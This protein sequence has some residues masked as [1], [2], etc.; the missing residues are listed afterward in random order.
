MSSNEKKERIYALICDEAY[1]PMKIK[2]MAI[3]LDLPKERRGELEEVLL[4]LE[5]E[6]KIERTAKNKYRKAEKKYL[7][8][9]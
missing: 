7:I 1:V 5:A 6:G 4:E 3:L 8:G 9:T 2:E